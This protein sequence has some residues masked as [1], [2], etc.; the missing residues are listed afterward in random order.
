ML[1]F[2]IISFLSLSFLQGTHYFFNSLFVFV[3]FFYLLYLFTFLFWT[4]RHISPPKHFQEIPHFSCKS[5]V[6]S[7]PLVA[8]PRGNTGERLKFRPHCQKSVAERFQKLLNCVHLRR[9]RIRFIDYMYSISL[10]S[11]EII[12]II[13]IMI[14]M[15][16]IIIIITQHS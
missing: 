15:H 9:N 7:K 12:I 6:E 5:L 8:P 14:K 2:D 11:R 4:G 1:S 10:S 16:L 3:L 13:V